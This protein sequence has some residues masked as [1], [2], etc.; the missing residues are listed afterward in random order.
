[1]FSEEAGKWKVNTLCL[2]RVKLGI[3][4]DLWIMFFVN[5]LV[6]LCTVCSL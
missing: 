4:Q 6:V 5:L 1:M 3:L 2:C